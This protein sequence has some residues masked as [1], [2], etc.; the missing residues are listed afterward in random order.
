MTREKHGCLPKGEVFYLESK[1]EPQPEAMFISHTT[2]KGAASRLQLIVIITGSAP[3]FELMVG[4]SRTQLLD[5]LTDVHHERRSSK[6]AFLFFLSFVFFC[7]CC[8]A[9]RTVVTQN[10]SYFSPV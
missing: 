10:V 6:P 2:K 5:H 8:Y 4:P 3:L 1:E 9:I 7:N